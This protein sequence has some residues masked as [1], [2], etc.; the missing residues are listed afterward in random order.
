MNTGNSLRD[1]DPRCAVDADLSAV[2]SR[3]EP[4]GGSERL[5]PDNVSGDGVSGDR[6]ARDGEPSV[7][8]R[9]SFQHV[10]DIQELI[11]KLAAVTRQLRQ[12]GHS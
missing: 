6:V 5:S 8:L 1:V 10:E 9:P 2:E 7:Q 3:Q 12:P 4:V 11:D